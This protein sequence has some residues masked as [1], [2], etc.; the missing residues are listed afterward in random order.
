MSHPALLRQQACVD[1]RWRDA[2]DARTQPILNPA[3]GAQI[4]SVPVMEAQETRRTRS[5]AS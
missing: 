1:G 5:A 2:L 3:N 4:G